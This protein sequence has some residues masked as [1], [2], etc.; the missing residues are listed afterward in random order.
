MA[1]TTNALV[2]S[3]G[4]TLPS[5][6][7]MEEMVQRLER[8]EDV[9]AVLCDTKAMED[10]I[11]QRVVSQVTAR[12]EPSRAGPPK[13][14]VEM[15]PIKVDAVPIN[16]TPNGVTA[17]ATSPPPTAT[18]AEFVLPDLATSAAATASLAGFTLP[19]LAT[20]PAA[21]TKTT[22]KLSLGLLPG[23]SF[24]RSMWWDLKTLIAMWR[25]PLYTFTLAGRFIPILALFCVL[26]IPLLRKLPLVGDIIP[27]FGDFFGN[28]LNILLLYI[29]FKVT[30]LE[31]Q[32]YQDF[33]AKTRR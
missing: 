6:A 26:V 15:T 25:D 29:A 5:P 14:L 32:R 18:F 30:S 23:T 13:E 22:V 11:M 16:N 31:L 24:I 2:P 1:D 10:R 27:N 9:V 7:E 19:A 17:L 21:A 8:L 12:T 20:P 28:L 3:R 33:T 4:D